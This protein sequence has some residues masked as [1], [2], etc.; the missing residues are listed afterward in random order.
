M[1]PTIKPS[2]K[3]HEAWEKLRDE[4][5]DIV[6]YGGAA[7]GGKSWLGCEWI[8]TNCYFFP[9]TRWFIG[10]EE[11]KRLRGS[12]LL[13]FHKV[14][15][16]HNIPLTDW[17][18]NGQDNYF[19]FKNG[20]RIDLLDLKRLPSD[21]LYERYGSE[22]FTGGW[23]EEGGEVDFMAFD[24]LKSRVGRQLNIEYSLRAKILITCNPKKNWIYNDYYKP[25]SLGQLSNKVAFIQAKVSDNPFISPNYIESLKSI[26]D[27]S[28][29][30]R[31][32][33]GNWEYDSDPSKLCEYDNILSIF[34]NIH[35][36]TGR[37][38]ITCD[39]AR[40]GSDKAIILVWEGWKVLEYITFEISKTTEIQKAITTLM[41]KYGVAKRYVIAD[42]DGVGGGVIDN[43]G[44][45]GFI[46]NAKAM[47]DENYYNLQSQCCYILAEKINNNELWFSCDIQEKYRNEIIEE[48]EQLKSY[49]ADKDGK[50]RILPKEK[51]KDNI[52]RSPDWRDVL[53]MRVY[54]DLIPVYKPMKVRF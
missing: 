53:M 45:L 25:Y 34:G 29:R 33:D 50:L 13:T 42:E 31:L 5:T 44:I 20:S 9:K 7:A 47:N 46:N 54:F 11:L 26:K 22:E 52:G 43:T 41:I 36:P 1:T 40:M 37:R 30:E 8:L 23:I 21:P 38:Y 49:N 28:T 17:T 6:I 18:F 15:S 27:A 51:I 4:E 3:Q 48:L 24:V 19:L 10:R 35:I 12:T 32:L 39:V 16:H 2:R 14:L